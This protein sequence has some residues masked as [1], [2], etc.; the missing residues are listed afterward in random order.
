M[1][2]AV[3]LWSIREELKAD[4]QGTL[5]Q[6]AAFGYPAI[7]TARFYLND[8]PKKTGDFCRSI[9]LSILGAHI[10]LPLGDDKN[11]VLDTMA[12]LGTNTLV[13][14]WIE[15]E[16]ASSLDNLKRLCDDLNAAEE[17]CRANGLR[18]IYH[19]HHFELIPLPDGSLPLLRIAEMTVPAIS[20]EIDIY[21]AQMVGVDPVELV[22][23][24]PR[25]VPLLHIK[26]GS[27]VRGDPTV[28]LGEGVVNLAGLLALPKPEAYI[29]EMNTSASNM[30][31]DVRK[32]YNWLKER[33]A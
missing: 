22:R 26:D 31:E 30:M 15:P 28:P 8:D 17:V 10:D 6:I 18:L 11:K 2:I 14:P 3:Q 23:T 29:V 7:E 16:I 24:F 32:S 27:G 9:G 19:N 20:F 1:T 5:R 4:Y 33:T 13:F 25:P 21:G 12:G